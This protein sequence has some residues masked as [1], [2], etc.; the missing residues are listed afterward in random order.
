MKPFDELEPTVSLACTEC[1]HLQLQIPAAY[2]TVIAARLSSLLLYFSEQAFAYKTT[3][4]YF[5]VTEHFLS[6]LSPYKLRKTLGLRQKEAF[7]KKLRNREFALD[8][9]SQEE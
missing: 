5:F 4:P 6:E 2:V 1:F 8:L 9:L 3:D 7:Q